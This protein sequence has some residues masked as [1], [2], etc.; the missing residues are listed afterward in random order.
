MRDRV[1]RVFDA[2]GRPKVVRWWVMEPL[3]DPDAAA[4]SNEVDEVRWLPPQEVTQAPRLDAGGEA[5]IHRMLQEEVPLRTPDEE[6]CARF[7]RLQQ[8]RQ[9]GLRD[10]AAGIGHA[11]HQ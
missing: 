5:A 3:G 8:R 7:H 11:D 9:P 1:I 4:A 2:R 6:E 10:M